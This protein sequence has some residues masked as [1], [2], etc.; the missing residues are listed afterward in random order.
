M[1]TATSP[2]QSALFNESVDALSNNK[3]YQ[4]KTPLLKHAHLLDILKDVRTILTNNTSEIFQQRCSCVLI[5]LLQNMMKHGTEHLGSRI[6]L[7]FKKGK[8]YILT[9][10]YT[11]LPTQPTLELL[12]NL[13]HHNQHSDQIKQ[14]CREGLTTTHSSCLGLLLVIRRTQAPIQYDITTC[15]NGFN[16]I[17]LCVQLST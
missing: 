3:I 8:L 6:E 7:G 16:K 12:Q 1:I 17:S 15:K 14:W 5:E 4:F 13:N 9:E 10:N 11:H 2:M